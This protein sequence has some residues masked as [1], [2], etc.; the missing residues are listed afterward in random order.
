MAIEARI[1]EL[2]NKREKLKL[3]GGDERIRK[4]HESGKLT[5][6]P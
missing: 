1:E 4:Q 3:G 2:R 6:P 5:A